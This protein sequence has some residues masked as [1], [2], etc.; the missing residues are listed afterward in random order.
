MIRSSGINTICIRCGDRVDSKISMRNGLFDESLV[1]NHRASSNGF[2]DVEFVIPFSGQ[3]LYY[4]IMTMLS[5]NRTVL[6][7]GMYRGFLETVM[8]KGDALRVLGLFEDEEPEIIRKKYRDLIRK[9]HPDITGSADVYLKKTQQLTQAYRLL[10]AEGY[11][12]A[13][14]YQTEWGIREN[15]AAFIRRPLFMEEELSGSG[16][17]VDTGIIGRYYW[18]PEMEPFS[19]LL[20]S[21][22]A[23]VQKILSPYMEED[24]TDDSQISKLR[25]KLL[26]LLIQQ[27]VDPYEAIRIIDFVKPAEGYNYQ[28]RVN[29]HVK[30][31]GN[32]L[33]RECQAA[34]YTVRLKG[35]NLVADCDEGESVISFTENALYYIITP[36]ILQ[37][38]AEGVLR[39]VED[40]DSTSRRNYRKGEL[41]LTVDE[42][43]GWDATEKINEEIRRILAL[44]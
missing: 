43:K 9:Y 15:K 41:L 8:E 32:R 18:D 26:H 5:D 35:N 16:M 3:M 38:A 34:E 27:F 12:A 19:L 28:Y 37:G 25:I 11:L 14:P 21:V 1:G 36:M 6:L 30:K 24:L 39:L 40:T 31:T 10:K 2:F 29:C 17:I 20:R 4:I 44:L 22:N 13:T 42:S 7:I 33:K 23:A